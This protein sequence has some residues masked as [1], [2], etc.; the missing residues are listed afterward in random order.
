MKTLFHGSEEGPEGSF[1]YKGEVM[2]MTQR[3]TRENSSKIFKG[4]RAAIRKQISKKTKQNG[5]AGRETSSISANYSPKGVQAYVD[6]KGE[7]SKL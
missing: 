7:E 3:F 2:C 5:I 1:S 6:D 4:T